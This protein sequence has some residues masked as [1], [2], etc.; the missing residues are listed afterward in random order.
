VLRAED[1]EHSYPL[2]WRCTT[3][4]L[5]MAM[6]SWYVRTTAVK[7]RL[8]EV[9]ESVNW[10]PAHIKRGRYGDWLENNVDWAISRSRYWGTPL[11]I[12]RCEQ[13][14][15]T[16]IGSLVELS[17]R[18]GRDL[19]GIDP[20]R[21]YIDD[22]MFRC[23]ECKREATRVPEVIDTWYDSGAMPFAQWHYPFENQ[24]LIARIRGRLS[25]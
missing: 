8:L 20:H 7:D 14:H 1:H 11:P 2:C 10:F 17:E 13:G 5:Y 25:A 15:A 18:A 3:P 21:P 4:L 19:T 24:E 22:V 9:N 6:T 23:P 12:W 16:A